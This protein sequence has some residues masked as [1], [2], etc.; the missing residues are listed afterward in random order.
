[1]AAEQNISALLNNHSE[2]ESCRKK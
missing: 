2:I 1:L